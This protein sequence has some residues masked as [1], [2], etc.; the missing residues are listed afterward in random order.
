MPLHTLWFF[1]A[2]VRLQ[3]SMHAAREWEVTQSAGSK[4]SMRLE[5]SLAIELFRRAG[6][7][8]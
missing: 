3:S 6:A 8:N 1:E 7:Y 2:E 4:Q 5:E